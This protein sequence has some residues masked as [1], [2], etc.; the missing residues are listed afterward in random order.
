MFARMVAL[1]ALVVG[2]ATAAPGGAAATSCAPT[3]TWRG[4]VY[5][6]GFSGR[7]LGFGETVGTGLVPSCPSQGEPAA[8]PEPVTLLRIRGVRP[9]LA[10]APRNERRPYIADG[11]V[12]ESPRHP[13]HR[14]FFPRGVPNETAGWSCARSFTRVGRVTHTPP[15]VFRVNGVQYFLDSRTVFGRRLM[16]HGVPY[17]GRGTRVGLEARRCS[18]RG[19]N[20]PKLVARRLW[21]PS[22]TPLTG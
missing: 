11:Y 1:F 14:M 22:C 8:P 10:V 21:V 12:I 6:G 3:L 4:V 17:L 2:V 9:A 16:R 20:G 15:N 18:R 5:H 13:L 7:G 19:H